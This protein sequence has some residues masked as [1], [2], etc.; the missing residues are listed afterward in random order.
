[1]RY[2]TR[3]AA[4]LTLAAAPGGGAQSLADRVG[5]VRDGTVRMTFPT[6]PNVCTDGRGSV[7]IQDGNRRGWSMY[8]SSVCINAPLVVR[9]GRSDNQTVS[10]RKWIGERA[11][12]S[13]SDVD[14]GVVP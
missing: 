11:N 12:A 2:A 10:V 3:L 6:R 14:L 7:W 13:Q 1:M 4:G 5:P 8:Q 9:I